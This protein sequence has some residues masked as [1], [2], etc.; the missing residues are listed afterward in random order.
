MIAGL[1]SGSLISWN[2]RPM[3]S[4][5]SQ[6]ACFNFFSRQKLGKTKNRT[7]LRTKGYLHRVRI[8]IAEKDESGQML[9]DRTIRRAPNPLHPRK[10]IPLSVAHTTHSPGNG[11]R[12]RG[13]LT[14]AASQRQGTR[15]QQKQFRHHLQCNELLL[16]PTGN[17]LGRSYSDGILN[18][19]GKKGEGWLLKKPEWIVQYQTRSIRSL[20]R[21]DHKA[22][23]RSN[24]VA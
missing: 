7:K 11:F 23:A 2:Q 5:S 14:T 21:K 12:I 15:E 17:R 19:E 8:K 3:T 18:K 13:I 6:P 20:D 9:L 16:L 24:V 4:T 10:I 22:P 1:S